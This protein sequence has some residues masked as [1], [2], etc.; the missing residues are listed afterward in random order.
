MVLIVKNIMKAK[1]KIE[2]PIVKNEYTKAG[3]EKIKD[4]LKKGNNEAIAEV[5]RRMGI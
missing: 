1:K 2:K 5:L 4:G 3:Q